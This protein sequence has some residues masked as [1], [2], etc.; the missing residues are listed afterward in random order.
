MS[1]AELATA[2]EL[3]CD[4]LDPYRLQPDGTIRAAMKVWSVADGKH[5]WTLHTLHDLEDVRDFL[6]Y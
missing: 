4:Y 5:Y 1:N 6:G 3:L 2:V